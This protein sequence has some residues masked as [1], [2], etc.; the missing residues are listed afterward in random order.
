MC[1][2]CYTEVSWNRVY[3][4]FIQTRHY[5]QHRKCRALESVNSASL[6][7]FLVRLS[8][9]LMCLAQIYSG[10]PLLTFGGIHLPISRNACEGGRAWWWMS[11]RELSVS[12]GPSHLLSSAHVCGFH[13]PSW[14]TVHLV[15]NPAATVEPEALVKVCSDF[16]ETMLKDNAGAAPSVGSS[17]LQQPECSM[18]LLECCV[19]RKGGSYQVCRP[20]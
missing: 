20:L 3:T 7:H 4:H 11:R 1:F 13:V 16:K 8:L 17:R 5:A 9:L 6:V 18:F 15:P 12:R 2:P 19:C 14:S 10:E